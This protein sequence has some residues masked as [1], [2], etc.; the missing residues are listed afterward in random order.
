MATMRMSLHASA[1]IGLLGPCYRVV[2]K[3][4]VGESEDK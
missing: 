3:G 4:P 2:Q 1:P